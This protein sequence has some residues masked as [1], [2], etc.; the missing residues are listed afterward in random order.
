MWGRIFNYFVLFFVFCYFLLFF[1]TLPHG[2]SRAIFRGFCLHYWRL[3]LIIDED[4]PYI[5]MQHIKRFIVAL[6]FLRP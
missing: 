2:Q 6:V 3:D 1:I 4:S 5:T